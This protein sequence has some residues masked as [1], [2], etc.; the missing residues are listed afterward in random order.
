VAPPQR[1]TDNSSGIIRATYGA[2]RNRPVE[3]RRVANND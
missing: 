3:R 1:S 2:T